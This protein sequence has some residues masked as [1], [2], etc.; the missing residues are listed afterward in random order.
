MKILYKILVTVC[1]LSAVTA[2]GAKVKHKKSKKPEKTE[3]V[4]LNEQEQRKFD[5]YFLEGIRLKQKEEYSAAYAMFEHCLEINPNSA[6]TLY[7]ISL[8]YM[9]LGLENKREE[10]L[11]RAIELDESNFWYKQMLANYYRQ[12]RNLTKAILVYEDMSEQFPSKL[13]PLLSLTDLYTQTSDYNKAIETLDRLEQLDG[14]SE[15]LSMEKFRMYLIT[16]DQE[17]A[18]REIESLS[19][20]YPFDMGYK[21]IL[22]DAYM[23][24][25]KLEEAGRVYKEIL[26]EY[27]SYAP[28]LVSLANYYQKTG[29]DSLYQ[30][31]LDTVL[32]NVNVDT[33]VK[34]DIMRQ[35]IAKNEMEHGDSTEVT[36]LFESILERPQPNADVAMLYA[37]YLMSKGMEKESEPVLEKI[38]EI[39]PENKP[40]RLQLLSFA[41]HEERLDDMIR[42]TT[43]ALEYQPDALEYYYYL[44]LAYYNKEQLDEALE[45]FTK[46][47]RQITPETDKSF[48]SDFYSIIGDLSHR[49]GKTEE[50]YAAYDSSLVYNPENISTLNNYAY[51]LSVEHRDLDKA[52]EMSYKTIKAEPNNSTYLDTYAWILF[53][54]SRY[55]EARIYID[56]AMTNGGDS[57]QVIVE[58]CGDIYFQL[59][60]VD[61]AVEYWKQAD[62]TDPNSS[63]SEPRSEA[64]L[65]RLKEKIRLRKY[66][67]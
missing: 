37:Q 38:L 41:I 10:A 56:Q 28:A 16:G 65:K 27:P 21:N 60:D 1:L 29:N 58:H 42:I 43:N 13:E 25:G 11:Q 33:S 5:Y 9:A 51:Y 52:E 7:E 3:V 15:Q 18:F 31:Q 59:G 36:K 64:E 22:G 2:Y 17:K 47:V 54:K 61:K 48:A 67:P 6:A 19:N 44:G 62:A 63:S 8:F 45:V 57:S 39:D 50:A 35:F 32:H 26:E 53:E 4:E 55:I 46:G 20:E 23:N 12:K 14:K 24:N 49:K 66:I 40:A 34:L 30:I